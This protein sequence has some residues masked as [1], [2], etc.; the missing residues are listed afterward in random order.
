MS[1]VGRQ[2]GR[3]GGISGGGGGGGG[4]GLGG[5][6]LGGGGGM[7]GDSACAEPKKSAGDERRANGLGQGRD[8]PIIVGRDG[9]AAL[10]V[11]GDVSTG[12]A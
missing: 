4:G 8:G 5:G 7:E 6:V 12:R 1:E 2:G 9:R 11:D 10:E 3:G